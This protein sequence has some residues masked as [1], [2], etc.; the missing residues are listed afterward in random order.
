MNG[1]KYFC[2]LDL[3][4]GFHQIP[5][6]DEDIE[7]TAFRVGTGGLYEYVR[8]PFGLCNA[9]ATFM[10]IMDK[11]LGDQNFQTLLI[12]LDDILIFAT[13]FEQTLERLDMVL[14]RL[15]SYNLKA[16][17]SKCHLFFE[18]LRY[19]GHIVSADGIAP[20]PEK[21]RA[22]TD[23][24]VP[25]TETELRGFLGFCGYY[26][27]FIA[28]YGKIA[29]PLQTLVGELSKSKKSR[30]GIPWNTECQNAFGIQERTLFCTSAWTP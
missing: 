12:Y 11:V 22:T 19:L 28:N 20:D 10:R 27:K 14:T 1:A 30:R 26:R 8:M 17:P 2:S 24:P 6:A 16:K 9:H 25:Q 18:K 3:A 5:V 15:S 13:T 23:W 29:S 21:T 7:K 4:H